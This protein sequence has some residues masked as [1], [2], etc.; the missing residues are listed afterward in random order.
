M[1]GISPFHLARLYQSMTDCSVVRYLR[2]RRLTEAAHRLAG[3]A[4]DIPEVVLNSSY[5]SQEAY[6][7]AMTSG[8]VLCT[9]V[10]GWSQRCGGGARATACS[11][12]PDKIQRLP[13]T[14]SQ[15]LE[16]TTDPSPTAE[17]TRFTDPLR[18]SPTAKMPG[19]EAAKGELAPTAAPVST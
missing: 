10:E 19:S 15:T 11:L 2:A 12:S 7:R 17:A 3:G 1:A 4:P 6:T 18:T 13:S 16:I 9:P 8:L 14:N 5:G